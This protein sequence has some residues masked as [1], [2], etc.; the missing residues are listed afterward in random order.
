MATDPHR[1]LS[2]PSSTVVIT[3]DEA[4]LGPS[5]AIARVWAQIRRVAPYFRAAVITAEPGSGVDAA[6]RALHALSPIRALPFRTVTPIQAE[7]VFATSSH[8]LFEGLLFL[9]DVD[10]LSPTAQRALLRKLRIRGRSS[11][12]IVAS[13]SIELRASVSA[14]RFSI[15]L[16]EMLGAVRISL[17]TL[18]ERREDLPVLATH[19]ARRVAARLAVEA[20]AF[21]PTFD[22][23][24]THFA[25]TGNLPQ[26]EDVLDRILS[27]PHENP[28]TAAEF[29]AATANLAPATVVDA[30]HPRM[31]RLEDVVQ[32][33]IR[34]VLIGCHGNK[35]R[36][37]EVLGISRST[38]YRMLDSAHVSHPFSMTG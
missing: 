27:H 35:L 20:P 19:I 6:A 15:E 30:A 17:P 37:A 32:E 11:W 33:H 34:A 23:A 29:S 22:T 1:V 24:L 31:L 21:D 10:R 36:A 9:P 3:G 18:R 7:A 5:P 14:G 13:S 28:V 2:F 4:L 25:W 16:A 8:A 12:R 38:L 26:L